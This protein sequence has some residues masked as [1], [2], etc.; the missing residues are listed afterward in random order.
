MLFTL[1][2]PTY[3]QLTLDLKLPPP[4]RRGI[5][6]WWTWAGSIVVGGAGLLNLGINT[7]LMADTEPAPIVRQT[8]A[9]TDNQALL[10]DLLAYMNTPEYKARDA[11]RVKR[12]REIELQLAA[13]RQEEEKEARYQESF[14][15][16]ITLDTPA[17]TPIYAFGQSHDQVE[18]SCK[19]TEFG[20]VAT[21]AS[22]ATPNVFYKAQYLSSCTPGLVTPGTL[23]GETVSNLGWSEHSQLNGAAQ[24]PQQPPLEWTLTGYSGEYQ[25]PAPASQVDW[26]QVIQD[27]KGRFNN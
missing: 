12:L 17:G 1:K 7:A 14:N 23:L 4:K 19:D 9:A 13:A 27:I 2:R 21:L 22:S 26:G 5:P 3:K 8:D 25:A 10:E 11:A 16:G 15:G 18:V 6:R 24:E 20:A